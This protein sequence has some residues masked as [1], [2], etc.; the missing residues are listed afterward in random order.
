M[1]KRASDLPDWFEQL[2]ERRKL[3]RDYK[4]L[5]DFIARSKELTEK[6][7]GKVLD[8]ITKK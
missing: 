4:W 5:D 2:A 6:Y 8:A 3:L 7:E 1:E